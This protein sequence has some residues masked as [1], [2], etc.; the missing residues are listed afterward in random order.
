MF[1]SPSSPKLDS[2][3]T[4]FSVQCFFIEP[5]QSDCTSQWFHCICWNV[6]NHHLLDPFPQPALLQIL[7]KVDQWLL[8]SV[9]RRVI[10]YLHIANLNYIFTITH[11]SSGC[12]LGFVFFIQSPYLIVILQATS[13]FSLSLYTMGHLTI[14][15]SVSYL[16][17]VSPLRT[18]SYLLLFA[19]CCSIVLTDCVYL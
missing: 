3:H 8:N 9:I 7:V 10:L 4:A 16:T 19:L 1:K 5:L 2:F 6:H 11:L 17:S 18:D 14:V 12:F 15:P 13:L